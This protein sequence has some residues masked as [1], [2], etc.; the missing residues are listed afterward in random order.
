MI[1]YI[2]YPPTDLAAPCARRKPAGEI[3]GTAGWR[4]LDI[5]PRAPQLTGRID[6]LVQRGSV[7][8]PAGRAG[9]HGVTGMCGIGKTTAAIEYAHRHDD[10]IDVAWSVRAMIP[11]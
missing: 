5:L 6:L 8:T 3:G 9:V 11:S 4:R 2:G 1:I 7:L 10:K